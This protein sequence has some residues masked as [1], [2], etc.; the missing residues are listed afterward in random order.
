MDFYVGDVVGRPALGVDV[1]RRGPWPWRLY[2]VLA[3][4]SD[5]RL[6]VDNHQDGTRHVTPTRGL[7]RLEPACRTDPSSG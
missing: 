3:Q 7:V 5:G 2:T 1:N 4:L 6:I